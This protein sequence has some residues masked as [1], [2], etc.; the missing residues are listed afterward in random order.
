MSLTRSNGRSIFMNK[1]SNITDQQGLTLVELLVSLALGIILTAAVI[2]SYLGTKQTFN[3]NNGLGRTQENARFS[4]HF[5]KEDIRNAGY[6]SCIGRIRNKLTGDPSEFLSHL[7]SVIGWD[8]SGTRF[9]NTI[10]LTNAIEND[11][12]HWNSSVGNLPNYLDDLVIFGSDVLSVK[13]Y[14]PI[15]VAIV[16]S[17]SSASTITTVSN[18]D[19]EESSILLVG[20]CWQTE[21][22]QHF[23][24]AS[25]PQILTA[26]ES[27]ST[28][29][30]RTIA[31]NKWL[32]DY[33]ADDKLL[34]YKNTYYYIGVGASGLSSLFRYET[35][36]PAADLQRSEVVAGSQELVEGVESM[37]VLYGED[38]NNDLNPNRYVSAD[39]VSDWSD[40]VSVRVGLLLRSINESTD[41]DQADA[42]T[43]LDNITFEHAEEDRVLRYSVNATIELRNKGLNPDLS[44]F[45]C[46]ANETGCT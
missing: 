5:L 43:L 32:R 21:L 23:D 8:A 2:Q 35:S 36:R 33:S 30:N 42:Y 13:R 15:N 11:Q 44:L 6:S 31:T 24:S 39:Q 37:Q 18:H 29:G 27:G 26:D 7:D 14:E 22:F 38:T 12:T 20:D 4:L 17:D 34:Q 25:D 19:I 46:N 41:F 16:S 10:E 3:I 9:G 45:A 28:P 1:D 40:V